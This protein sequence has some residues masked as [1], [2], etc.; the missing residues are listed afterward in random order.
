MCASEVILHI[1]CNCN[2][3]VVQEVVAEQDKMHQAGCD[4]DIYK[5]KRPNLSYYKGILFV[6][7]LGDKASVEA[8]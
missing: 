4:I 7:T 6:L 5:D 3:L 1:D 2:N 8:Q